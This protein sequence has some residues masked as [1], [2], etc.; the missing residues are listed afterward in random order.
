[1]PDRAVILNADDFG[2][3][4]NINN[5]IEFALQHG[6]V[7]AISAITSFPDCISQLQDVA[8]HYPTCG[9]GVHL[10]I[11]T[12]IPLLSQERVTSLVD[13]RGNF[14]PI[15]RIWTHI[16]RIDPSELRDELTARI[17]RLERAGIAI[18][19]LSDHHGVLSLY[20]PF[21]EI[22]IELAT[23]FQLPVRTPLT[24]STRYPS[25]FPKAQILRRAQATALRFAAC[26]PL[27]A[28]RLAPYCTRSAVQGRV[29][30]LDTGGIAHPDLSIGYF[31][32]NPTLDNMLHILKHLPPGIHEIIFHL[33]SH[34][35]QTTYPCGLDQ[36]Y[37]ANREAELA[38]VT[39][40]YVRE[41][42][43]HLQIKRLRYADIHD[44]RQFRSEG[45]PSML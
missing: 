26:H 11:T 25:S 44:I 1:M 27:K 38:I 17:A 18:D 21:F 3:A 39:R 22:M 23:H 31:W 20:P 37:F 45:A 12:G 34:H 14:Y 15:E 32:R 30:R 8:R 29:R 42:F 19:H 9:I 40:A 13:R 28:A 43:D 6:A 24:A 10:N 16:R 7:N 5:G 33:G 4:T 2:A 36:T 41:L 35:R